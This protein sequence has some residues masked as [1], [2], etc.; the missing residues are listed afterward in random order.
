MIYGVT[1]DDVGWEFSGDTY[2]LP[3]A[4]TRG[5]TILDPKY[6]HPVKPLNLGLFRV[7]VTAPN[8]LN[9]I[10]EDTTDKYSTVEMF[11]RLFS[12]V[13]IDRIS[14]SEIFEKYYYDTDIQ[15]PDLSELVAKIMEFIP[16]KGVQTDQILP[17]TAVVLTFQVGF[18]L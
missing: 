12:N 17:K 15:T 8:L 2:F 14:P 4:Q 11:M 7:D 9:T 18:N 5:L 16:D 3:H 6:N 1:S 13:F 10:S